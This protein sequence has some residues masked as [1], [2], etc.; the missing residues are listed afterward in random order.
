MKNVHITD[1]DLEDFGIKLHDARKI[2][3]YLYIF[4]LFI[5]IMLISIF[6]Y[7]F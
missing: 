5:M 2:Y 3:N 7:F 1:Y 6:F 4:L